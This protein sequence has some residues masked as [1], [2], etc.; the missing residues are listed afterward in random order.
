MINS[1]MTGDGNFTVVVGGKPYMLNTSHMHYETL[2]EAI[3]NQDEVTFTKLIDIERVVKKWVSGAFVLDG[4]RLLY[5]GE[6]V[7]SVIEKRI[8]DMIA[9]GFNY[10][11]LLNFLERVYQNPSHRAV[12]ELYKF[13]EHRSLPI[14]PD[15]FFLAYKSVQVYCGNSFVDVNGNTVQD[16]DF[17]DIHSGKIRNNIGDKPSMARHGVDD[18]ANIGCSKGLHVGAIDYVS[19]YG[20]V[21]ATR[22]IVKVDPANVVSVPLDSYH[23]KVRCC[24][25]EVVDLFKGELTSQVHTTYSPE[26]YDVDY[27][28]DYEEDDYEDEEY[29]EYENDLSGSC[30]QGTCCQVDEDDIEYLF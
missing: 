15:G 1:I 18:N 27:D 30:D 6:Q 11:P 28:D 26:D 12:N 7:E 3:N 19:S 10:K 14:T 20:G 24:E 25:Y 23:Q 9:E 5:N 21:G 22:L 17:V 29:D 13:L 2:V 16:G 4:D 8:L